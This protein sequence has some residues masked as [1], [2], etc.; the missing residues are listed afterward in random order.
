MLI[1]YLMDTVTGDLSEKEM[2][3]RARIGEAMLFA[4]KQKIWKNKISLSE[5]SGEYGI[6]PICAGIYWNVIH[7]TFGKRITK[8]VQ[9]CKMI[10]FNI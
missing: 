10:L 7:N 8:A 6:E 1:H 9:A 4:P 2:N 3:Y 5:L